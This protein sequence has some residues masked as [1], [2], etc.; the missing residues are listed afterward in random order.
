MARPN[1]SADRRPRNETGTP[2]RPIVRAVV[3]GPPPWTA[4]TLPSGRIRRSTRASPATTITRR[5]AGRRGQPCIDPGDREHVGGDVADPVDRPIAVLLGDRRVERP[6]GVP[7]AELGLEGEAHRER[8]GVPEARGSAGLLV[9]AQEG[10]GP[11]RIGDELGQHGC[12]LLL[13]GGRARVLPV[14]D[15][16]PAARVGQDV[17]R[18]E[19]EMAGDPRLVPAGGDERLARDE[20]GHETGKDAAQG[21][22]ARSVAAR[23]SR[24]RS[25]AT[26]L[27]EPGVHRAL[28]RDRQGVEPGEDRGG[29]RRLGTP[30]RL[31]DV[32]PG[33]DA[34]RRPPTGRLDLGHDRAVGAADRARHRHPGRERGLL[35]RDVGLGLGLAAGV[36]DLLDRPR[37]ARG[38]EPP[39]PPELAA[40]R[41]H[42]R[43]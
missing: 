16:G 33:V 14:H 9:G 35:E 3:N 20:L 26:A 23:I 5:A 15:D 41:G 2:S 28:V 11:S 22:A 7:G 42:R 25:A 17:L 8:R 30:D 29:V 1:P 13:R 19:V 32:D 4:V 39:D 43:S 10:D 36:E 34:D 6:F 24:Q 27:A 21:A 18:V 37:P 40:R 38:L 31:G 12:Q